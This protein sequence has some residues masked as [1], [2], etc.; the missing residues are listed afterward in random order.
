MDQHTLA[1]GILAIDAGA[2]QLTQMACEDLR[3]GDVILLA[4]SDPWAVACGPTPPQD[5]IAAQMQQSP[6]P[7]T[8]ATRTMRGGRQR[9]G[10]RTALRLNATILSPAHLSMQDVKVDADPATGVWVI[11]NW[12]QLN[13]QMHGQ[14]PLPLKAVQ[15]MPDRDTTLGRDALA[16][17]Y[18]RHPMVAQVDKAFDDA[19]GTWA[20]L[21]QRPLSRQRVRRELEAIVRANLNSP[22]AL[23]REVCGYGDA[24][25]DAAYDWGHSE[26][27]D[28]THEASAGGGPS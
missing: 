10:T 26:A 13:G 2:A 5:V 11:T 22:E 28:S 24:L 3:D 27:A 15:H 8:I 16:E 19:G 23:I 14:L 12:E 18:A 6:L 17:T 20:A 1:P 25:V 9:R 7:I 21:L 4:H